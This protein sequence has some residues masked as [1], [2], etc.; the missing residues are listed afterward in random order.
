MDLFN[1]P[2]NIP[3]PDPVYA[4]SYTELH[5]KMYSSTEG[6]YVDLTKVPNIKFAMCLYGNYDDSALE[7]TI[8]DNTVFVP[9]IIVDEEDT[10]CMTVYIYA[11]DTEY[12]EDNY[13]DF[14][15]TFMGY[16]KKDNTVVGQGKIRVFSKI[17][18]M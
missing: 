11:D 17:K 16:D 5:F 3:E 14:Q 8:R 4:G 10:S 2:Y 18:Q 15:I 12:F 6:M 1:S 7:F 13:Y 9:R